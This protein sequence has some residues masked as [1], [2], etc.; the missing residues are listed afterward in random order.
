MK[1]CNYDDS[2]L[3]K[4]HTVPYDFPYKTEIMDVFRQYGYNN[5]DIAAKISKVA[6]WVDSDLQ[7]IYDNI[8]DIMDVVVRLKLP[9]NPIIIGNLKITNDYIRDYVSKELIETVTGANGLLSK[10]TDTLDDQTKSLIT[11]ACNEILSMNFSHR[12]I[13]NEKHKK[14][15]EEMINIQRISKQYYAVLNQYT[16]SLGFSMLQDSSSEECV[17]KNRLYSAI[18]SVFQKKGIHTYSKYIVAQYLHFVMTNVLVAPNGRIATSIAVVIHDLMVVFGLLKKT[19]TDYS[20]KKKLDRI[21][22]YFKVDSQ[23]GQ[24]VRMI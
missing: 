17:F 24:Y 1:I 6:P 16:L 22:I 13:I 19:D 18:C 21:K 2:L 12:D 3:R 10:Q 20:P 4:K 15:L 7:N 23:T 14:R 9:N 5:E 8:F 11:S